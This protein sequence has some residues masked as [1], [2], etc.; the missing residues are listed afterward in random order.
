MRA[1]RPV[2][3]AAGLDNMAEEIEVGE[4]EVHARTLAAE[5]FVY[6]E[7]RVHEILIV[8]QFIARHI[9]LRRSTKTACGVRRPP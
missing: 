7:G 1:L 3:N 9:R 4:I 2:R 8:R 6:G 5:A